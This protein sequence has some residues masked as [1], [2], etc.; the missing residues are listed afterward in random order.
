M[1]TDTITINKII[2][3]HEDKLI[4]LWTELRGLMKERQRVYERWENEENLEIKNKIN[5]T[6]KTFERRRNYIKNQYSEA[7]KQITEYTQRLDTILK[8]ESAIANKGYT[9]VEV[10]NG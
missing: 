6:L 4:D 10:I 3:T 5:N 7:I 2:E 1:L 9:K 8:E